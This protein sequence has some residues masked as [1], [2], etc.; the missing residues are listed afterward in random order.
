LLTRIRGKVNSYVMKIAKIFAILG[1][2]PIHLT[3]LSLL[4]AFSAFLSAVLY[5][6]KYLFLLFIT[7][8]GLMDMLDGALARALNK[9]SKR[10]AFIDS[11]LDRISDF[12]IIYSLIY[13]D[14]EYSLVIYLLV[15]SFMISY[16]RAR[17][18]S[19]GLSLEGVGI[20]ERAER[21]IFIL[22]IILVSS[23]NKILSLTL[24]YALLLLSTVTLLQRI[25]FVV[26]HIE[27]SSRKTI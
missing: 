13:F 26:I 5:N 22:V 10:G 3:I 20:I 17:S 6:S 18:E 23:Y 1:L 12:F 24:L 21:I 16:V 14:F 2:R 15:V 7:L 11:T 8:S 25:F 4:F 27:K 9:A 19:L